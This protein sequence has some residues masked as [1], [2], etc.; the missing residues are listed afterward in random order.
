MVSG[1]D[2]HDCGLSCTVRSQKADNLTLADMEGDIVH[3]FES[4]IDLVNVFDFNHPSLSKINPH[5]SK[6]LSVHPWSG[7]CLQILLV[8]APEGL[9]VPCQYTVGCNV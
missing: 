5:I 8:P 1:Q 6:G 2:F 9:T 3:R 4:A 7:M